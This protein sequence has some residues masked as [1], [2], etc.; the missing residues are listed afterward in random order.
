MGINKYEFTGKI[1]IKNDR[2][3]NIIE[4]IYLAMVIWRTWKLKSL[5]GK[6]KK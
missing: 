5:N 2:E 1:K 4:L 3:K 6:K